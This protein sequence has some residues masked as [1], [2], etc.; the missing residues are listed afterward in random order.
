MVCDVVG[1][2]EVV[3]PVE[4]EEVAVAGALDAL[5]ELLGDDLVRV[6]VG[7]RQRDGG[8][9]EDVDGLHSVLG[10]LWS[11]LQPSIDAQ[12]LGLRPRLRMARRWRLARRVPASSNF[13]L[14]MSVK[15][16]VMAAAA[17]ISGESEVGAAS[18]AL[19]AFEV[20]VAGGGAAF[21]GLQDVG[22]HAETHAAAGLAPLEAGGL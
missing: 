17:A 5:E 13:Q 12:Y 6:D 10:L 2:V 11:G 16:P 22:V 15:W 21:A 19:A 1:V 20:A 14:R 18:A 9:G 4:E 8:A 7:Q 3:A